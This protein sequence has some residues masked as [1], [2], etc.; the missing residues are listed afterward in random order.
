ME[1]VIKNQITLTN[2]HV[3]K[4]VKANSSHQDEESIAVA[5]AAAKAGSNAVKEA[6]AQ[7]KP[8]TV[9]R[10]GNIIRLYPNGTEEIIGTL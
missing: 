5:A 10:N 1:Q 3:I 6:F 7:G 2:G 8:V 4:V 9:G